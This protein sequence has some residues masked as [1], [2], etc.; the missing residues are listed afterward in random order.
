MQDIWKD[1]ESHEQAINENKMKKYIQV[2]TPLLEGMAEQMEVAVVMGGK[3]SFDL[4][5][6]LSDYAAY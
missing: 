2:A 3:H 5:Y 4:V 6:G 1:S